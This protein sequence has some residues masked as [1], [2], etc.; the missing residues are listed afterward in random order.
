MYLCLD[1]DLL[2]LRE[3]GQIPG[4]D[5]VH[6]PDRV[7]IVDADQDLN[8]VRVGREGVITVLLLPPPRLPPPP[9]QERDGEGGDTRD[10]TDQ[11]LMILK[12]F[13]DSCKLL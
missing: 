7:M 1:P 11:K 4:H 13:R 5:L 2:F 3:E 12:T 6:D 9:P 10:L 8:L